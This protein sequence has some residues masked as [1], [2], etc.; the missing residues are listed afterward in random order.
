M[1][2]QTEIVVM[3]YINRATS[4]VHASE[5]R[6]T[7]NPIHAFAVRAKFIKRSLGFPVLRCHDIIDLAG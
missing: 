4:K 2:D 6:L 7:H 1:L 5:S 3:V